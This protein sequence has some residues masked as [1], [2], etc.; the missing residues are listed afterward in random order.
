M[1]SNTERVVVLV[2]GNLLQ[3]TNYCGAVHMFKVLSCIDTVLCGSL[4]KT[5]Y[6][7]PNSWNLVLKILAIK[8]EKFWNKILKL[9]EIEW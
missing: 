8:Y 9:F 7:N 2:H 3:S 6:L 5:L 1:K 4:P